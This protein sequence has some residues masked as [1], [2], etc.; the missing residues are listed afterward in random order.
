MMVQTVF[1]DE[2]MKQPEEEEEYQDDD[3]QMNQDDSK[4]ISKIYGN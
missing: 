4:Y 1:E 3:S 2:D